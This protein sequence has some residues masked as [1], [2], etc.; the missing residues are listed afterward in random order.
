MNEGFK[1]IRLTTSNYFSWCEEMEALLITKDLWDAV[2]EN[3]SFLELS[4]PLKQSRS[5]KARA[6][7]LM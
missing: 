4:E 7:M 6:H 3:E 5:A 1:V 2:E